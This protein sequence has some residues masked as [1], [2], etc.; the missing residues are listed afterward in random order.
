MTQTSD[1]EHTST[2]LL[3]L[4]VEQ[5]I[6]SA[7]QA[8]VALADEQVSGMPIDEVLIARRWVSE[9]TLS[10]VAPWLKEPRQKPAPKPAEAHQNKDSGNYQNNLKKYR[11]LMNEILGE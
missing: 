4:L 7:A 9:D 6:I 11:Q 1:S 10:K 5:K 2:D 3:K 8:D